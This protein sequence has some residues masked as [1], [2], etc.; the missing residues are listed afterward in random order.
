MGPVRDLLYWPWHRGVRMSF[1]SRLLV[2]TI[3]AAIAVSAYL[4]A[5]IYSEE[6]IAYVVEQALIQ[7]L[8]PGSDPLEARDRLRLMISAIPDRDS[9][10]ERLVTLSQYLEKLQRL[11]PQELDRL[12]R[13]DSSSPGH[14]RS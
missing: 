2:T 10:V 5:R 7:K 1:R 14:D 13:K 12:L 4:T 3:I 6:L 8:P 11:T 9:K